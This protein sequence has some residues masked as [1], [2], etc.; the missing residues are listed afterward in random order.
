MTKREKELRKALAYIEANI[1]RANFQEYYRQ[2]GRRKY[3]IWLAKP[4][5]GDGQSSDNL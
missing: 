3:E 2:D 5:E 4:K 1:D